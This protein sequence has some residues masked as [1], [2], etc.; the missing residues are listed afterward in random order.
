MESKFTLGLAKALSGGA[1]EGETQCNE[2]A[3][4]ANDAG[5][6]L[7]VARAQLAEA[8][9]AL[10]A[11]DAEKAATLAAQAQESFARGS[12]L[13]SQWRA[14]LIAALAN[15]RRG[16][17]ATAVQQRQQAKNLLQELEKQWGS[18]AFKGY[19]ARPD[20]QIYSKQLG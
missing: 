20:I 1:K 19:T 10:Q 11:N 9:S 2:A 8:E 18:G 7:L 17:A 15:E 6:T 14:Y 16:E 4:L 12:Q 5:E 13:E 3:R